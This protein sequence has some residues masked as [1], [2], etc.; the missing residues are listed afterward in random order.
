MRRLDRKFERLFKKSKLSCGLSNATKSVY[1]FEGEV[2]SEEEE[3]YDESSQSDFTGR[4]E[5]WLRGKP[6]PKGAPFR[7]VES[8]HESDEEADF[9]REEEFDREF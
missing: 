4:D 7:Q 1:S 2:L 8:D 3:E 6:V 9:E 5:D